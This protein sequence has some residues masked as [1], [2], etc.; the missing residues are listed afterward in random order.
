MKYKILP[1]NI[2][3]W[4]REIVNDYFN[5][6]ALTHVPV[7]KQESYTPLTLNIV[8]KQCMNVIII[9]FHNS[10][11]QRKRQTSYPTFI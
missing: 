8:Q 9:Q 6:N 3:V 4:L 1:I 5:V 10:G 11:W 7:S 2:K